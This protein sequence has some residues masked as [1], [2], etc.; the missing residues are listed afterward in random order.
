VH[1]L[2]RKRVLL[3]LPSRNGARKEGK[4]ERKESM[5]EKLRE[6][7]VR[8]VLKIKGKKK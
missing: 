7:S 8:E 3:P 1:P 2:T 6:T 4:V 5:Q